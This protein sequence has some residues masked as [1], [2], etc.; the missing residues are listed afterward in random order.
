MA[1]EAC[2]ERDRQKMQ[3]EFQPVVRHSEKEIA[4]R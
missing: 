2:R 1:N 4:K 3:K